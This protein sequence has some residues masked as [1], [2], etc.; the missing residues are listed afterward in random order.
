MVKPPPITFFT[1][2]L[3]ALKL[4]VVDTFIFVPGLIVVRIEVNSYN[5][6]LF[7]YWYFVKLYLN[8]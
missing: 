6:I 4:L 3:N 8:M 7:C 1:T 2:N 5:P